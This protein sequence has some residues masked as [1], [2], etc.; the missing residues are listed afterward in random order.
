MTDILAITAAYVLIAALGLNGLRQTITG[1]WWLFP[2]APMNRTFT[3]LAGAFTVAICV[4]FGV[5]LRT[6]SRP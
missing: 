6:A 4:A 2:D 3:R 1:R 5:A